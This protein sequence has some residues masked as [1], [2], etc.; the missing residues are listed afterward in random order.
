MI[1]NI[2]IYLQKIL[3]SKKII[4]ERN[5]ISINQKNVSVRGKDTGE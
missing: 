5:D 2:K 3:F 1:L 4:P